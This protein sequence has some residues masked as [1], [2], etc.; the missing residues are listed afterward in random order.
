[1]AITSQ[2]DFE[3]GLSGA[4]LVWFGYRGP[5]CLGFEFRAWWFHDSE[6]IELTNA[7]AGLVINSAA[8]LGVRNT[9]TTAGDSL[10]FASSLDIDVVDFMGSYQARFGLG[11]LDLGAGVR[12]SRV[13]QQ[14]RHVEDPAANA[15]LDA[16]ESSHAFEGVGPILALRGR[17]A[18]TQR[19]TALADLRYSV[20]Y[21]DFDQQAIGTNDNVVTVNRTHSTIDFLSIAEIELGAEYVLPRDRVEFFVDGA[22]VAQVWQ[23]AGNAANNDGITVLVDPEVSDKNADMALIGLR[24]GGGVRF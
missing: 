10:L 13:E 1:V 24:L 19:L 5:S 8:P 22:F 18:V 6:T 7:G 23:G 15:L 4:P 21:G 2:T 3:Y 20:L 12:Y 16:V 9:S 11:T 17:A 14:Y